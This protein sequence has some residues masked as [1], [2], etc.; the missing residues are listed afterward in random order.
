MSY[1]AQ[2]VTQKAEVQQGSIADTLAFFARVEGQLVAPTVASAFVTILD[3]T[4]ATLVART[5][6]TISGNKLTYS[7]TW[8]VATYPL[9][10]DYVAI[11]E[12]ASNS[13]SYVDRQHFDVVLVRLPCLVDVDHIRDV[14][15]NILVHVLAL[16]T[17][18]AE[19]AADLVSRFVRTGWSQLLDRLRSGGS[20]PSL[21]IDRQRLINPAVQIICAQLCNALA[22]EVDD[23]WSKRAETHGSNYHKL[24]EGLG[25]LK[26]DSTEDGLAS[27]KEET[28]V[29]R[30]RGYV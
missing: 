7:Q 5:A 25:T 19:A 8:P 18:E 4:G 17:S 29:N 15:P 23:V 12:W 14:Y 22:R 27:E 28:R 3:P 6:A 13:I 10:E 2:G 20:R 30:H 26:Y 24:F 11:W 9:A 1:V 21:V 16:Q